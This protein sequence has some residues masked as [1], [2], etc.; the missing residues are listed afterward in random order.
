MVT[1]EPMQQRIRL[2]RQFDSYC[3]TVLKNEARNIYSETYRQNKKLIILSALSQEKLNELSLCD[4]YATDVYY[5]HL[6]DYVVTVENFLIA[7]AIQSLSD[8]YQLIILYFY[9][10]D[11][12]DTEIA[13]ELGISRGTVYYHKKKALEKIKNYLKEHENE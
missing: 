2:Q 9:F 5:F 6:D 7:N 10:L 1:N 13:K 8:R 3:K 12:S 4:T 11:M